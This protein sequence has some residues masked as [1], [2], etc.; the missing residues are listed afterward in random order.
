MIIGIGNDIIDITRV[1]QTI[2][3]FGD[4]FLLRVF[5]ETERKRCGRL[6]VPAPCFAR[7]FAAKEAM[8]KALG[9]GLSQGVFWRDL[10]VVNQPGGKPTF[11]LTGG[12]RARLE[13]MTPPGF[14]AKIDLTITDEPPQAHAMVIISAIPDAHAEA[15]GLT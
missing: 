6:A 9:T 13:K 5:T 14:K 1:E 7:R 3:R 8:S 2:A 12:A 10:A 4:R 15:F 11:K